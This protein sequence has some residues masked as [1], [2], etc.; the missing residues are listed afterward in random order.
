VIRELAPG[1]ELDLTDRV[2]VVAVLPA[3][4]TVAAALRAVEEG[5]DVL[6]AP[7]AVSDAVTRA[8]TH[9][10]ATT[11]V[12]TAL[13]SVDAG[14][15]CDL[16][17]ITPDAAVGR[18]TAAVDAG[19]RVLLTDDVRTVRRAVDVVVAVRLAAAPDGAAGWSDR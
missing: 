8:V 13:E 14:E 3:E 5:A 10:G 1:H 7:V 12:C 11:P 9:A 15:T 19:V 4:H 16:V 6:L 18:S 2:A 17:G